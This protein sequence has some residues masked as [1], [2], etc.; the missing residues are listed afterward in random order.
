M[1]WV[2]SSSVKD[3]LLD[4]HGSF[5]G[6]KRKKVWKSKPFVFVLDGVEGQEQHCFL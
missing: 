3:T 2:L 5:V 1:S 4:W 6:K